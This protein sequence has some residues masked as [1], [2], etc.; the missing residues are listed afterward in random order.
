MKVLAEKYKGVKMMGHSNPTGFLLLADLPTELVTEAV[1]EARKRLQAGEADLAIHPGCGT[2]YA[3]S[4]I[5]AGSASFAVLMALSGGKT[6]KW[7]HIL[8]STLVACL[9]ISSQSRS[10]LACK[11]RTLLML[12]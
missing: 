11:K 12:T 9:S 2:N 6:P 5:L 7:W 4:S 3:A 10:V 1:L 8:L